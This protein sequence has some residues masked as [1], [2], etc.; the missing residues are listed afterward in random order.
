M[1]FVSSNRWD[2]MGAATCGFRTAWINRTNSADE[3]G[4]APGAV[5]TGL[6]G[7]TMFL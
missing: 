3:Y 4:P 1:V 7:L 5:L 6:N 2:V